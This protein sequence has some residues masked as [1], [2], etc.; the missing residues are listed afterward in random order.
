MIEIQDLLHTQ[1]KFTLSIPRLVIRPGITV[2]VGSNGAGK[3]TLLR[4]LAT[5]MAPQ[6]G[7][8]T[9]LGKTTE[10][11]LPL[12]RT[13]TGYVPTGI[14]LY[15]DMTPLRFLNYMAELKGVRSQENI[16][17]WLNRF[18]LEG[19]G[20]KIK[21]LSQGQQQ[22]LT[23]AQALLGDPLFLYLDEV[24][25]YLDSL[26]KNNV[27][28][29]ISRSAK[30]R[31]VLVSTHEMNDWALEADAVLWLH[32]GRIAFYGSLLEWTS[33]LAWKVWSGRIE[34]KDLALIP[35][36]QLMSHQVQGDEVLI[37]MIGPE[38]PLAQ[39]KPLTPTLEDAYFI[40][41][42]TRNPATVTYP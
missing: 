2:I 14:E 22:K 11:A 21:Q 38:A 18:G 35:K 4:L 31:W 3:S 9:Y 25:T 36:A 41:K 37:R 20:R 6:K 27:I 8:I 19:K 32:Q 13:Y 12:I 1:G 23:I 40:R 39:L 30:Q 34:R 17:C 26:E 24:L 29:E 42:L 16:D 28:Q 7:T 5:V 15:E 10:Q 33:D